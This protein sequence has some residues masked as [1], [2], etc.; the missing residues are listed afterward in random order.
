M[1][2]GDIDF[3]A[4]DGNDGTE[5]ALSIAAVVHEARQPLT[6]ARIALQLLSDAARDVPDA[7]PYVDGI[8]NQLDR[9]ERI[10][11]RAGV[12]FRPASCE[13]TP[14]DLVE[15]AR[16]VLDSMAAE[17]LRKNAEVVA[18]VDPDLPA[19]VADPGTL[20]HILTN[21]VANAADAVAEKGGGRVVVVLRGTSKGS[22]EVIVADDGRG[23]DPDLSER[24]FEPFFSTKKK[25]GSGLGLYIVRRLVEGCGGTIRL[26][27]PGERMRLGHERLSMAFAIEF[28]SAGGAQRPEAAA[29][30]P[31]PRQALNALVVDDDGTMLDILRRLVE[32]QGMS[33]VCATSGED[34][35]T[36]LGSEPFDLLV[37]D[38]NLPGLNGI[39][40][41]RFARNVWH[42]MPILIITAY[43][44]EDS[45]SEAAAL[46]VADYTP[47]PIDEADF[48]M[49]LRDLMRR[50]QTVRTSTR[51]TA[52]GTGVFSTVPPFSA[53]DETSAIPTVPPIA[54]AEPEIELNQSILIVA[55]DDHV[56]HTL[57]EILSGLGCQVAAFASIKHAQAHAQRVGFDVLVAAAEVLRANRDWL[58]VMGRGKALGA[59]AIMERAGVD[60]AI[61][62]IHLG[63]RGVFA[64]PFDKA[65]ISQEF[66]RSMRHM[67]EDRERH[68]S[69]ESLDR[70]F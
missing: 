6:A 42:K 44:S 60:K 52:H 54:T 30:K 40:V 66:R 70:P 49:R 68:D 15:I 19:V 3:P 8:M 46:G 20:E 10:L 22:V 27:G 17:L 53:A 7:L 37:T 26:L 12:F 58:A 38:K 63:A 32:A 33:C 69:T 57:T 23:L 36:L 16:H 24:I 48:T 2:I 61:E 41:A 39:E 31:V 5:E 35:V 64:P 62:A 65:R 4:G 59:V 43:A 25:H 1:T 14:Q 28:P 50:A 34:A 11:E 13:P 67:L 18:E 47:K 45:A 55:P 29:H 9:L 51:R 56:R 21:L